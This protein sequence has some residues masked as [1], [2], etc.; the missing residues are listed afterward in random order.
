MLTVFE[1]F[2]L[3][4]YAKAGVDGIRLNITNKDLTGR[5]SS[6]SSG[7][8][9]KS[10]RYEITDTGFVIYAYDY[11]YSLVFG[12]SP[13]EVSAKGYKSLF[14]EILKWIDQ[15]PVPYQ[16]KKETVAGNMVKSM[17]KNG[18]LIWQKFGGANTGLVYE[19]IDDTFIED[20]TDD[21]AGAIIKGFTDS[22]L[23]EIGT[24]TV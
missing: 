3:G 18:T 15:K 20:L 24:A 12:E 7:D 10:I 16:G 11:I 13:S 22:I 14:G 21:L 9:Y 17:R 2:I 5:G 1:S 19:V 6:N 23:A 4:K 8:L